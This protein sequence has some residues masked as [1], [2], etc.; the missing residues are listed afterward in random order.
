MK[1]D[2][3]N[4]F[5]SANPPTPTPK[6]QSL[7]FFA[8]PFKIVLPNIRQLFLSVKKSKK[9]TLESKI[10]DIA[11]LA[12]I[13]N[14]W[15]EDTGLD[16]FLSQSQG[17]FLI[18]SNAPKALV[19]TMASASLLE[20]EAL[21]PNFSIQYK[22]SSQHETTEPDH[23]PNLE[24]NQSISSPK[25]IVAGPDLSL[26]QEMTK[27]DPLSQQEGIKPNRSS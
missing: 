10:K 14:S 1:L 15:P 3:K 5:F 4:L 24:A 11:Y 21:E 18:L 6:D 26:Q 20:P 23:S 8:C 2:N 13:S 22:A 19:L 7:Y 17:F 27:L 16:T 12:S 25:H 9:E